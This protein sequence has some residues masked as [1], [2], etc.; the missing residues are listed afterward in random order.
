M[1]ADRQARGDHALHAALLDLLPTASPCDADLLLAL[2]LAQPTPASPSALGRFFGVTR[3]TA[4]R[5][6]T[7]LEAAGLVA[8]SA[9]R[10]LRPQAEAVAAWKAKQVQALAD[11]GRSW[12][13]GVLP[14]VLLRVG[15][16]QQLTAPQL[17]AAGVIVAEAMRQRPGIASDAEQA[18]QAGVAI[19][20]LRTARRRLQQLG[21]IGVRRE[22]RG[23]SRMVRCTLLA[24]AWTRHQAGSQVLADLAERS[25]RGAAGGGKRLV[26][27]LNPLRGSTEANA[28]R[29]PMGSSRSLGA[30]GPAPKQR[31]QDRRLDLSDLLAGVTRRCVAVN[32]AAPASTPHLHALL[33][34]DAVQRL[35]RMPTDRALEQALL[36]VGV[37]NRAP[38]RRQR[39]IGLLIHRHGS[40]AVALLLAVIADALLD[41]VRNPAAVVAHRLPLLLSGRPSLALTRCS[42]TPALLI[43]AARQAVAS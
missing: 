8:V 2:V 24:R 15:R 33:A 7:Q 34:P 4:R 12:R 38:K 27:P 30:A 19:G 39:S 20:T 21:I 16:R 22:K 35:L 6:I 5:W 28:L 23:R 17:R 37:W 9:D 13:H 43:D 32:A 25:R 3:P 41:R 10:Y 29:A 1:Q 14:V 36:A 18:E 11:A 26:P 40:S 31:P 42:S